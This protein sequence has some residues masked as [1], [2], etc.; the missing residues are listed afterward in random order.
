[1]EHNPAVILTEQHRVPV[2]QLRL[3]SH[4]L[5]RGP[6]SA[7]LPGAPDGY[8]RI[9]LLRAGKIGGQQLP[10]GQGHNS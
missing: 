5:G 8:I 9:T 7:G 6:D 1:M 4:Q 2:D 10:A 3:V